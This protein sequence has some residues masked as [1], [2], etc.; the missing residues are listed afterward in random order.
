MNQ[1]MSRRPAISVIVPVYNASAT[2]GDTIRSLF[3]QTRTDYEVVLVD[4]GSTDTKELERALDPWRY[5]IRHLR[6]SNA[7]AGAARNLGLA[8]ASAPFIAFLDADDRW[9][10]E[11][12]ER[13]VARL[14]NDPA[15][16]MIWSDGWIH[17]DTP[18]SGRRYFD[19]TRSVA[20]PSFRSLV[21]QTCSVL[22]SSVV[23]RKTAIDA[24]G[25]FDAGLRRGQD[26][27][28]WLRLA[29]REIGMA[30]E[31]EPLVWRR[32]HENNLSG[33]RFTEIRRAMAVLE[34]MPHKLRLAADEQVLVRQRLGR[35]GAQLDLELGKCA[36]RTGDFEVAQ[37]HLSRT[38]PLGTW[39]VRAVMM[40]MRISPALL[41][42]AYLRARPLAPQ[43]M[44][45][46][47][48]IV[49]PGG[50]GA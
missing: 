19:S 30:V 18:L 49:T 48:A 24:V 12:L 4:D 31:P 25:G 2:I 11:F 44:R 21:L 16:D 9:T 15:C 6:Q 39:K 7:G 27:D 5:R 45:A 33:D 35:L 29:H 17:G 41:R 43:E 26:F 42:R 14:E 22:T 38:L 8:Y 3:S 20:A 13:Q 34:G 28:L 10:P 1:L 47:D 37:D 40:A 46:I 50:T 23:V 36:L 32:V